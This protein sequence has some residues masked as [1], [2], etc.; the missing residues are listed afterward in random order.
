[1]IEWIYNSQKGIKREEI[2]DT[3]KVVIGTFL[4]INKNVGYNRVN[5]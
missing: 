1:M 5:C 4:L 2:F 3:I